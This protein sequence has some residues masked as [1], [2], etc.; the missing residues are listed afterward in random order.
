MEST[1]RIRETVLM[2]SNEGKTKEKRNTAK[3][4][5]TGVMNCN[6]MKLISVFLVKMTN[7]HV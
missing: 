7:G 3:I 4:P 6:L 2:V 5:K 1:N